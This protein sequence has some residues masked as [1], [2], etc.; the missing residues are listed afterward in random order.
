[1]TFLMTTNIKLASLIAGEESDLC[2]LISKVVISI[3][4]VLRNCLK[5]RPELIL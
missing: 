2:S 3:V 5:V 4:I 1:M